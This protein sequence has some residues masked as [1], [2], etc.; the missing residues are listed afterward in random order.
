MTVFGTAGG[1]AASTAGPSSERREGHCEK[2]PCGSCRGGSLRGQAQTAQSS[3]STVLPFRACG[4]A[5]ENFLNLAMKNP[6]M[7][8]VWG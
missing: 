5:L 8:C 7:L 3:S 4:M 1:A 6:S 2:N